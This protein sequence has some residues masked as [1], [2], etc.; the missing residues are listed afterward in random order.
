M[1]N[2]VTRPIILCMNRTTVHNLV[3][4]GS[5]ILPTLLPPTVVVIGVR[6]TMAMQAA[7]RE[8]TGPDMVT[9]LATI[10]IILRDTHTTTSVTMVTTGVIIGI[11]GDIITI[12]TTGDGKMATDT[13]V[14]SAAAAVAAG[15]DW[16]DGKHIAVSRSLRALRG[17][18]FTGSAAEGDASVEVFIGNHRVG[19]FFN[20]STGLIPS[21][22]ADLMPIGRTVLIPPGTRIHV[23]TQTA[24]G[25]NPGGITLVVDELGVGAS[26]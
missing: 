10:L 5:V 7:I 15:S 20:S 13:I 8:I 16:L 6:D 21:A 19:E 17:F 23:V 4:I 9:N 11:P 2:M 25:T 22:N 14:E 1:V 26:R 12:E 18:G 3:N 24:T